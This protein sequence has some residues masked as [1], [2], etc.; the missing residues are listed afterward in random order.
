MYDHCND[1]YELDKHD[2]N[3]D[4]K[5]ENVEDVQSLQYCTENFLD[6]E[7]LKENFN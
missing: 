1:I 6:I 7:N 4:E 3:Q 2:E 5:V